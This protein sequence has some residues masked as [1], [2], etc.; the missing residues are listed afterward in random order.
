MSAQYKV[1]KA[2]GDTDVKDDARVT[3]DVTQRTRDKNSSAI[4]PRPRPRRQRPAGVVSPSSPH[5]TGREAS[6]LSGP[7]AVI[8]RDSDAKT[9]ER[10]KRSG[11]FYYAIISA[12]WRP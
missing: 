10:L 9:N 11:Q 3:V 2:S 4:S 7:T 1:V 5:G 8:N 12:T 6:R